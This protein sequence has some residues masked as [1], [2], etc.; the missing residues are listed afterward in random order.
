MR[1]PQ[2]GIGN[3]QGPYSTQVIGA[4]SKSLCVRQPARPNKSSFSEHCDNANKDPGL[5]C[6]ATYAAVWKKIPVLCRLI[7]LNYQPAS[8]Q[9]SHVGA[10]RLTRAHRRTEANR[11]TPVRNRQRALRSRGF[12]EGS[13]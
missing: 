1:N 6:L 8:H 11:A 13:A 4:L 10:R 5:G 7:P 9:N 3:Y 2:N 12:E